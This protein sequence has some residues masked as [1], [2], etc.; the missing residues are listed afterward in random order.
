LFLLRAKLQAVFQGG[1]ANQHEADKK[2][3]EADMNQD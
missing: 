3:N 2:Q 1:G